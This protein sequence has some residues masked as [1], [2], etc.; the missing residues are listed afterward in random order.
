MPCSLFSTKRIKFFQNQRTLSWSIMKPFISNF[1][2]IALYLKHLEED[3]NSFRTN[4]R[5]SLIERFGVLR[6]KPIFL[7]T[8]F[9]WRIDKLTL[10]W[11]TI[12]FAVFAEL[13]MCIKRS[14]S[15]KFTMLV[16]RIKQNIFFTS[17][18]STIV[19][20]SNWRLHKRWFDCHTNVN[21]TV[22]Q[23]PNWR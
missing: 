8:L 21:L 7:K 9:N 1:C 19:Q 22:V 16:S 23:A 12:I 11:A 4:V 17:V 2:C 14:T 5:T 15:K 13:S 6:D 18:E 3:S 10:W 20:A